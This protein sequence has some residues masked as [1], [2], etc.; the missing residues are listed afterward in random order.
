MPRYHHFR[1]PTFD[2]PELTEE[3]REQARARALELHRRAAD[4]GRPRGNPT[5]AMWMLV[6]VLIEGSTTVAVA[7]A[8]QRNDGSAA[9]WS[10]QP[11]ARDDDDR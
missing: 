1:S 9:W 11:H 5:T 3:R 10:A 2:L 6:D 8:R 4:A 7:R